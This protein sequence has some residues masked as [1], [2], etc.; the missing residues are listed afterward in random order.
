M[1]DWLSKMAKQKSFNKA[2]IKREIA[3]FLASARTPDFGIQKSEIGSLTSDNRHPTSEARLPISETW[4][5]TTIG[6]IKKIAILVLILLL[7]LVGLTIGD[8]KT[9]F[10]SNLGQKFSRLLGI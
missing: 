9:P 2:Q 10:V 7:I 3:Q 6:E 4:S 5:Q 8:R 1:I